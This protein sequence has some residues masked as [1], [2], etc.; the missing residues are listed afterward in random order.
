MEEIAKRLNVHWTLSQYIS[1][2]LH[3]MTLTVCLGIALYQVAILVDLFFKY[4]VTV[5]ISTEMKKQLKFPG[6]TLCTSDGISAS[7]F[8]MNHGQA[9]EN[10]TLARLMELNLTANATLPLFDRQEILNNMYSNFILNTDLPDLVIKSLNFTDFVLEA[11]CANSDATQQDCKHVLEESFL[12]TFQG[13]FMCWTMFH[14][15]QLH[16]VAQFRS[17]GPSGYKQSAFLLPVTGLSFNSLNLTIEPREVVRF[18][19][20][21]TATESIA[22]DTF[23]HGIISVHDDDAIR[24]NRRQS[25]I[26]EPGFMYEIY[27]EEQHFNYL[28]S[29]YKSRCYPYVLN[30]LPKYGTGK[31]CVHQFLDY[32]LSRSDCF[33]GCMAKKAIKNPLCGCY[34]PDIPYLRK[35]PSCSYDYVSPDRKAGNTPMSLER[36]QEKVSEKACH[37]VERSIPNGKSVP[38]IIKQ[39]TDEFQKCFGNN[40]DECMATCPLDCSLEQVATEIQSISWPSDKEISTAEGKDRDLLR[41]YRKCCSVVSVRYLSESQIVYTEQPK[42]D[43]VEIISAM[44]GIVSLWVGFTFVGIFDYIR[45]S[46]RFIFYVFTGYG[47]E[48]DAD[49]PAVTNSWKEGRGPAKTFKRRTEG[50]SYDYGSDMLYDWQPKRGLKKRCQGRQPIIIDRTTPFPSYG[51]MPY[52]KMMYA[53]P[54]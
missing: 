10:L 52:N 51:Y 44:G 26:L 40:E 39:A 25:L 16:K 13:K 3:L 8:T 27:I 19:V 20:N 48:K 4:P 15:S 22:L 50:Q 43:P 28:P 18:L 6:I 32:P 45:H 42:Y 37:W 30:N 11:K 35:D 9:Y 7:E 14:G 23:A 53:H 29:P 17:A 24:L 21:L 41:E 5:S 12:E 33:Y 34:P 38:E 49:A 36:E 46:A 1:R 2:F 31:E 54:C 47:Q